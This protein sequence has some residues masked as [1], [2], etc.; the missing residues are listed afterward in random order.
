M[1]MSLECPY[2]DCEHKTPEFK[3]ESVAMDSLKMH[4]SAVHP[5]TVPAKQEKAKLPTL[6]VSDGV[7][8]ETSLGMFKQQLSSYKRLAG[9]STSSSG[10]TVLQGI[11]SDAYQQLYDR[12]GEQL[13]Q[14]SEDELLKNIEAL[15]VRPE[16][17]LA[18]VLKLQSMK[19]DS[20]ET[21]AAFSAKLRSAARRCKFEV[22]C[23]CEQNVSYEDHMVLY[24]LLAGLSDGETQED[25]LA[26][27]EPPL[28]LTTAE[29]YASDKEMAKRSREAMAA[30]ENINR[31]KS[32][33]KKEKDKPAEP[34]QSQQQHPRQQICS[35]CGEKTHTDRKSECKAYGNLCS[36]GRKHHFEKQCYSKGKPPK[37]RN[38]KAE[39]IDELSAQLFE[40]RVQNHREKIQNITFD[41]F[42]KKWVT[43]PQT[44]DSKLAVNLNVDKE[45]MHSFKAKNLDTL[46]SR[47]V[48]INATADTG[49]TVIC[50][51]PDVMGN[52]GLKKNQLLCASNMRLTTASS[53]K[54]TVLGAF[55]ADIAIGEDSDRQTKD[56]VYV[57][58]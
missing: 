27:T 47:S 26:I 19:Q 14:Q 2:P 33:Y 8:T 12:Y 4:I 53:A 44:K 40:L 21:V 30:T 42:R 54:L 11:P 28:T 38:E 5:A 39:V 7:V 9:L 10:D 41:R 15:L 49:A 18:H 55:T 56:M 34:K 58:K 16:N 37:V 32:N 31:L 24:Q 45:S 13:T 50:V 35:H 22:K 25:L 3:N 43:K 36:C 6:L 57:I 1:A 51:G 23:Q 46:K 17:K 20:D 29:K 52:L 48:S